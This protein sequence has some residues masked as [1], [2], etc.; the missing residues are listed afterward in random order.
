MLAGRVNKKEIGINRMKTIITIYMFS[1][2]IER[3][4]TK[5]P[6]KETKQA[7]MFIMA[8]IISCT[9]LEEVEQ[10]FKSLCILCLS[11]MRYPEAKQY[12]NTKNTKKYKIAGVPEACSFGGTIFWCMVN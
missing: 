2:K 3:K 6:T 1:Y 8:C 4:L 9:T 10:L 5:R 12:V 7:M 11:R